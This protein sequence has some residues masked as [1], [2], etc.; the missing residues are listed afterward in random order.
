MCTLG[1]CVCGAGVLCVYI[2]DITGILQAIYLSDQCLVESQ[3]TSN[4]FKPNI[5]ILYVS[6]KTVG[7]LPPT[8]NGKPPIVRML[9]VLTCSEFHPRTTCRCVRIL[10]LSV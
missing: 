5:S 2:M 10:F 7:P 6:H 4:T 3:K 9:S 8:N 1:V